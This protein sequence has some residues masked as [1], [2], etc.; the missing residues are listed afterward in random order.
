M[1]EPDFCLIHGSEFIAPWPNPHFGPLWL[2]AKC[3]EENSRER[4]IEEA[5]RAD[6]RTAADAS[7]S[8]T[9]KDDQ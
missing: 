9:Q 4:S 3:E 5:Q 1:D 7:A 6:E 8:L 2:C